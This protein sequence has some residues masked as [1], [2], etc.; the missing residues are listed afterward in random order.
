MCGTPSVCNSHSSHSSCSKP[1]TCQDV[2]SDYTTASTG[3]RAE[4][5]AVV[6]GAEGA[7]L[8]K[9]AIPT[10]KGLRALSL[11][12]RGK[13]HPGSQ[14]RA[15]ECQ[16]ELPQPCC[17]QRGTA[18]LPGVK[19]AAG[20]AAPGAGTPSRHSTGWE[21][22]GHKWHTTGTNGIAGAQMAHQGHK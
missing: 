7:H 8:G 19:Q 12:W 14:S 9:A 15:P 17:W 20:T 4:H 3:S 11:T 2:G 16:E 6:Q 18:Q 21:S 10:W 13:S 5:V 22:R 1:G